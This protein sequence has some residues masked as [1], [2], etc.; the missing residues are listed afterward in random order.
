MTS[1]GI[2]L[3]AD[4]GN[5]RIDEFQAPPNAL[6]YT[7][8]FGTK[9]TGNGDFEEA[10]DV[11][12]G[13][14]NDFYTVD[15]GNN[16]IEEF[17]PTGKY[18]GQF[19]TSGSG[20]LDEPAGIAFDSLGDAWVTDEVNCRVRGVLLFGHLHE[21][22]RDVR[23]VHERIRQ[24]R[25]HRN[26]P[27]HER[28]LRRR[29]RQQPRRGILLRRDVHHRIQD[30]VVRLPSGPIAVAV[31]STGELYIADSGHDEIVGFDTSTDAQNVVFGARRLR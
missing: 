25:R 28:H 4:L 29:R 30:N 17:S 31:T 11:A 7:G 19:G 27:D 23:V 2:V 18:S 21:P 16:R 22:V 3:V 15:Y 14:N 5:D 1:S 12:I 26:R 6:V 20:T 8:Q 24:S 13:P 9:G 10:A